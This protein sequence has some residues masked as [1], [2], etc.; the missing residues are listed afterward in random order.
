[1]KPVGSDLQLRAKRLIDIVL[2]TAGVVLL[3][4]LMI[5]IAFCIRSQMGRPIF[6]GQLRPGL[7]EQPIRVWKF[8]TM[9]DCRDAS[10][11]LLPDAERLTSLGLFLRRHSLDELPQLFNILRGD[12]S[13]VG[14]RPLLARYLPRYTA[15][16]RL[17]QRVKPGVTGW[18]Q[19]NGRNALN[20][21]SRL[22]HDVWYVENFSLWLDLRIMA[23]TCL[24]I[25][26]KDDVLPGAGSE[27]DEF[28]GA[29]G[30]PPAGPRAF[31]VE[32]TEPWTDDRRLKSKKK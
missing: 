32:A 7:D 6:Y 11:A 28:W 24:R 18:A 30:P 19:I 2:A 21:S 14:P 13:I 22:E 4:P 15:R 16:Q 3:S 5:V 26:Q 29:D 8:R 20:W 27:L 1:M 31:P 9:T 25:L 12:M 17:R 23:R 10:G